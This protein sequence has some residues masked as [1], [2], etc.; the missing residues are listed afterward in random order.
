MKK[1]IVILYIIKSPS[2]ITKNE[3]LIH[4]TI[5]EKNLKNI[6]LNE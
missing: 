3:P 1:I 2:A 4:A 6:M 5:W